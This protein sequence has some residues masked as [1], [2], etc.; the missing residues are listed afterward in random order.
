MTAKTFTTFELVSFVPVDLED[1]EIIMS[2]QGGPQ[3]VSVALIEDLPAHTIVELEY[4]FVTYPEGLFVAQDGTALDLGAM[5]G[6]GVA[7]GQVTFAYRG[8]STIMQRL[9]HLKS[10]PWALRLYDFDAG[11]NHDNWID[12]P[13]PQHARLWTAHILNV[14]YLVTRPNFADRMAAEPITDN[15]GT[16]M[17]AEAKRGV[18][19]RLLSPRSFNLG[20]VTTVSGLGGGSTLGVASYV[21]RHDFF[22]GQQDGTTYHELGHVLGYSHASTMTYGSEGGKAGKGFTPLGMAFAREMEV[23]NDILIDQ[24]NYAFPD[25]HQIRCTGA[26]FEQ[27]CSWFMQC[28]GLAYDDGDEYGYCE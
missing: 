26:G 13:E 24:S 16:L 18:L 22:Y 2:F 5:Y 15:Q 14:A 28:T 4:A 8:T 23:A 25:D 10:V 7:T 17:S 1:V 9:E 20:V 27:A 12:D 11:N 3:N 19:A 21:L 6:T